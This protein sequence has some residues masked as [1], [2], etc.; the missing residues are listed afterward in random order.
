MVVISRLCRDMGFMRV[1]CNRVFVYGSRYVDSML[2][3]CGGGVVL[4]LVCVPF[5]TVGVL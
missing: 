5:T 1:S 4:V 3:G 2:D